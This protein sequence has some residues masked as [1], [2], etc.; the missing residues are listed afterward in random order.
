[1]FDWL[2]IRHFAIASEVELEFGAGFTAITGETGSGKSLLVDALGILLGGRGEQGLIQQGK[3][4]A[5][6][7]GGF[8]LPDGSP[9]LAWLRE[10]DL[11]GGDELVLRRILRRDRPGRSFINGNPVNV[12]QLRDLGDRLVEIHGQQEHHSLLQRSV[13][14][15]L[16]DE[17]AGNSGL[18]DE[19]ATAWDGLREIGKRLADISREQESVLERIELLQFQL[20]ELDRLDPGDDEWESLSQ[21]QRRLGHAAELLDAMHGAVAQLHD[22]DLSV[23]GQLNRIA[24]RLRQL[25]QYDPA[26][27]EIAALLEE[28]EINV[29]ESVT[30]LRESLDQIDPGVDELQQVEERMSAWHAMARKYRVPPGELP[31]LRDGLGDSLEQLKNPQ[32]ERERL[33]RQQEEAGQVCERL[34]DAI[35]GNRRKAASALAR[36]ITA[37]MRELGMPGGR[38]EIVLEP[39]KPEPLSR[40]G[41]ETVTFLVSANA[42][43]ALQPLSRIASGGEISR[44]SLAIQVILADAADVPTMIFDEVDVGIGGTVANVVGERLRQL[45]KSCQVISVTHLPQVA[46]RANRHISVTKRE[47]ENIVDVELS[48]LER[49]ERIVEI[50]R[51]S[52]TDTPSQ[53]SRDHARQMLDSGDPE[54]PG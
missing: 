9:V 8:S 23:H 14:Q 48:L 42:G 36:K 1:M 52:G 34:A 15:A 16:L 54:R 12:S 44:I 3:E 40:S 37:A 31:G 33:E 10:R 27:G 51:M 13:Q 38:F 21:K 7:R 45:G 50:A 25:E 2:S 39:V 6:I 43:Q 17:A 26:T 41:R 19:L 18:L 4:E 29:S 30:R 46:S 47:R 32:A 24:G 5:E 28:A 11:Q 53:A 49:P 22:D 35:S 20:S